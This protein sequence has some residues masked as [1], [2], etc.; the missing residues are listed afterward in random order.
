MRG[1]TPPP[2]AVSLAGDRVSS[3]LTRG[4]EHHVSFTNAREEGRP[5]VERGRAPQTPLSGGDVSR[6]RLQTRGDEP[7]P[8]VLR[9][10]V[11]RLLDPATSRGQLPG[12]FIHE[13]ELEIRRSEE[14]TSEL[15]SH[16]DLVCRL[17]L[18][19]KKK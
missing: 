15:Q 13:R 8:P 19:K 14:H 3:P 11:D 17:L 6:L 2:T 1:S 18:E 7:Q 5:G 10:P 9:V 12:R 4:K 16:H